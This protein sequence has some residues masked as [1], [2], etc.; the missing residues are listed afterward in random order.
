MV[1]DIFLYKILLRIYT[2]RMNDDVHIYHVDWI[3]PSNDHR[4]CQ[5]AL[6]SCICIYMGELH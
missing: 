2:N 1:P 5:S 4:R 6:L 3:F